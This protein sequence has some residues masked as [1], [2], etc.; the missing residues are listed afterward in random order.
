MH[1]NE[2]VIGSIAAAALLAACGGAAPAGNDGGIIIAPDTGVACANHI[3]VG[4]AGGDPRYG[5]TM[6]TSFRE[7]S[8]PLQDCN[9]GSHT[10]YDATYCDAGTTYTVI[11]IAAGWCHPCQ[12]E[13]DLLTDNIVHAYGPHGVRVV[14]LLVQDPAYHVPDAAFCNQ[15]VTTHGLSVTPTM[16]GSHYDLTSGNIELL[17]PA[18]IS[19]IYFPDGSLPST[20]IVDSH[21]IIRFHENG[22]SPDLAS[23]TSELDSLLGL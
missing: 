9:G 10:F 20:L 13:S 15:W 17:D 14:Q 7:F 4:E 12:M 19:N 8:T 11:S 16:A 23:L 6:G 2:R 21:G 1:M 22:E 5:T 3:P 18:Q